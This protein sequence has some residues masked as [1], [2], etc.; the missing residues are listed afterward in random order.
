MGRPNASVVMAAFLHASP[1]GARFTDAALG[2]WYASLADTTALEE[3]AHH[4]RR[5]I[6]PANKSSAAPCPT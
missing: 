6:P 5:P 2:A 1:E 4:L 3:V